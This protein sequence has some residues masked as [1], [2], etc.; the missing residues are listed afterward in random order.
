MGDDTMSHQAAVCC[1]LLALLSV[2]AVAQGVPP[3]ISEWYGVTDNGGF[4]RGEDQPEFWRRFPLEDQ[5]WGRCRRDTTD[6]HSGEASGLLISEAATPPGKAPVQWNYYHLPIGGGTS[7]IAEYWVKTDGEFAGRLGTHFYDEDGNHLGFASV[8]PPEASEDWVHARGTIAVPEPARKIGVALYGADNQRTWYD[9]VSLLG[10][11]EYEAVKATPTID[12]RLDDGC[13]A[14]DDVIDRFALHT[15]EG[16]PAEQPR[17]WVAWDEREVFFAFECPHPAGADLKLDATRPDGNVWLDDSIEVFIDPWHDRGDYYQICVNAAGLLRDTHHKDT[18][19]D[20]GARVAVHRE[21]ERWTAEIAVP[22]E[23][24][25]PDMRSGPV[26]GMNFVRNDRTREETSTWSLGGFHDASRF[27]D[28]A[29]RPNLTRFYI[30]DL[31]SRLPAVAEQKNALA[32]KLQGL[33]IPAEAQTEIDRRL[34]QVEQSLRRLQSLADSDARISL[35]TWDHVLATFDD[36]Q[37]T[38]TATRVAALQGL[39]RGE[40]GGLRVALAGPMHKIRR[41]GPE[42]EGLL[43]DRIE[44]TAARDEAESFQLVVAAGDE[45]LTDVQVEAPPLRG[46]KG[47]I[48]LTWRI[49][50]YLET[51]DPGYKAEYVGWWPDPLLPGEPFGVEAGQRQPIWLTVEVPPDAAPGEYSSEVTVRHGGEAVTVPVSLRVRSFVLPRPGTLAT[52]FGLY[53]SALSRWWWGTKPYKEHMPIEM[54]REWSEFMGRYRLTPKNIAREYIDVQGG[55]E[56]QVDLSALQETVAPLAD[57]YFA[58]DSFCLHRLP[59]AVRMAESAQGTDPQVAANVTR[60]FA[61]QWEEQGLPEEVYIYGHD[62][63]R[64]SHYPD[65]SANYRAIREVVPGYPIMQTIGDPEP[66]ELVGLVDIWCPLTPRV[67]GE[68]YQQRREAGETLWMYTCCSPRPPHANFFVDEPGIDHRILFWQA[69]QVGATGFLYWAVCYWHGLP[70]PS[71]DEPHFPDVPLRFE[72]LGTYQNY[73]DNGDGVLIWPGHDHQPLASIRLEC[74]RDGIEDYEYLALLS[75]LI[76]RA[77]AQQT[78]RELLSEARE[79]ATVPQTISEDMTTFTKDPEVLLT[80]REAVG[81]MIERL[82]AEVGE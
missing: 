1:I 71:T 39:M 14:D 29:M 11:P 41:D 75:R 15:G 46:P 64:P 51:A 57:R 70:M 59:S 81:D 56:F 23:A 58:P 38:L 10:T 43:A 74:I 32:E 60:T 19:W 20:S 68:F 69:R 9:D 4:E 62:E 24:L 16:L 18:A 7:L 45:A 34:S 42:T 13:W 53:A 49:V 65:V 52:P 2:A 66:E 50:D 28:V 8:G 33:P 25:Q 47:E 54:F 21:D 22:Y 76:E 37:E 48:P 6:A 77:E 3:E 5:E 35:Q 36:I 79:L 80:R 63:P 55:D 73:K 61:E 72:R 82:Q 44:L 17:A 78:D 30:A 31:G 40:G 67:M 26:W 27:G 12:G